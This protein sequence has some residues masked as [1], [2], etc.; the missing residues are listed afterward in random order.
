MIKLRSR[1]LNGACVIAILAMAML[2]S[3]AKA[4]KVGIAAAVEPDAFSSLGG[5]PQT[6]LSIGKSIFYNEHIN[7]TSSGL[8]QV[9]LV[10]GSTFTVGPGSNLVIDKFVYDPKKKSGEVV[11]TFSKGV[12]RFVGGRLS[13]N[14]GGVTVKTPAG[15]L[16]I[17]GGIVQ[18]AFT[19]NT[20][21]ISFLFGDYA[22]LTFPNGKI[23]TA[24]QP[25]YTIDTLRGEVRP[26][27]Q[28]DIALVMSSLSRGSSR[29]QGVGGNGDNGGTHGTGGSF[30]QAKIGDV[31]ELVNEATT[32]QIQDTI[33]KQLKQ[34]ASNSTEQNSTSNPPPQD[35]GTPPP[36]PPPPPL[37]VPVRVL[38][39][40]GVYTA[41]SGFTTDQAGAHGI[42][43][44]GDYPPGATG[45]F[46]DD[47]A[48]TLQVVNG[49]L[50]GTADGL[51]DA[52]CSDAECTPPPVTNAVP[53][54]AIDLP[55]FDPTQCPN[56]PCQVTDATVTQ[57][58]VTTNYIG[59]ATAKPGFY[60]YQLI[61]GEVST[62]GPV[63]TQPDKPLL[64]FG[65]DPYSF[66]Q[67]S[68]RLYAFNLTADIREQGA[69]GPFASSESSPQI[70]PSKP[71]PSVSPLLYLEAD[72]PTQGR[73]TWLQTSF[74]INTTPATEGTSFDQQ[75]FVNVAL[76]GVDPAT[77]GLIGTRRGGS[78]VGTVACSGDCTQREAYA[79]TGDVATL[80]GPDGSHFLGT[81]N[82]NIV[83]GLDS[84]GTHNIGRDTPLDPNSS[85]VEDQSGATYHVG[86]GQ[87][88]TNP[89]QTMQGEFKGYAAGLVQSEIP[90]SGFQ[91]VVASTSTDDFSITFDPTTNS[92]SASAT[93]RDV[94]NG[95]G[96]TNAY[97]F[98]FGDD[99]G[100]D[101]RSA[102]IDDL[103]YA[104]IEANGGTSV[105]YGNN[106][107][108][109]NA[110]S[111]NYLVSGDQLG[112]TQ[113]FPETF[114]ETTPGSGVRPFCTNCEFLK[115]G[116]WGSRVEFGNG[117][118]DQYTDNLHLAWW[119]AGDVTA[120]QDLPTTGSATYAGH[121]IGNVAN[122][123]IGKSYV[124]AGDLDMSWN[125]ANRTGD[126]SITKFDMANTSG[127]AFSGA[128]SAPG[129]L[130]AGNHFGGA[131]TGAAPNGSSLSGSAVGSFVN[132]GNIKAAGVIGNWNVGNS[133]YRA[134]GIFGGARP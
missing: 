46:A 132:N 100:S 8:V 70:D 117:S 15:S 91:N 72:S 1:P 131:L 3:H 125:F 37:E 25:G 118:G 60:A 111:T 24:Y 107:T 95:D 130:A 90:A 55:W 51:T 2:S 18:A 81:E 11:A 66:G 101:V 77:G 68:G 23:L 49:R 34:L 120:D 96:A 99:G 129:V 92:L 103:H 52:S 134:V 102:Y 79:F 14:D 58:G 124:A 9:L 22:K 12:M 61:P 64:L 85:A 93:V 19:G 74:Y 127:L 42:L 29:G 128:M 116:A 110:T 56:G 32:T 108:Y 84:T 26:T 36:P 114:A 73:A 89:G 71:L 113:Y 35:T 50:I 76:G 40:P 47:F 54:A 106:Q 53:S 94:Q 98:E 105:S 121:V 16:A 88:V 39:A 38:S 44:G 112:V 33:D 78:Q 10:D 41:E 104:A 109:S 43:G 31:D 13:K 45:P 80:A 59:A 7:T 63:V 5:A 57:G 83:I 119:I 21:I 82:P 87:Q 115:W 69:I 27:S 75:S 6:Q 48:Q 28:Q 30:Q 62:E 67:A 122:N 123:L 86:T 133:A 126:L 97:H 65:G 20:H 4:D 17:R